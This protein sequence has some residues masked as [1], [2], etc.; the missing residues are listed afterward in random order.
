MRI[1]ETY[2]Q[3]DYLPDYNEMGSSPNMANYDVRVEAQVCMQT[4]EVG[5]IKLTDTAS[6]N[7]IIYNTLTDGDKA[8]IVKH[9][10]SE[11]ARLEEEDFDAKYGAF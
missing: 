1:I 3:V 4:H 5:A 7:P 11:A 6:Q 9:I 2:L 8:A 10:K